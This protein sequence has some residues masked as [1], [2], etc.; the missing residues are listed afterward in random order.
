MADEPRRGVMV[1]LAPPREVCELLALEGGEPVDEMHV[2]LFYLGDADE[3]GG[4]VRDRL[5]GAVLDFAAGRPPLVGHVGGAGVFA[6][7]PGSGGQHVLVALWDLPDGV[8][9]RYELGRALDAAGVGRGPSEH[10]WLP[11][12]TLLYSEQPVDRLP[13]VHTEAREDVEFGTL[14]VAWGGDWQHYPMAGPAA[15]AGGAG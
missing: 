2:T 15:G 11:H 10:G 14:V 13:D 5:E 1:A 3:L 9:L 8:A 7:S 12:T 6:P 4:Q